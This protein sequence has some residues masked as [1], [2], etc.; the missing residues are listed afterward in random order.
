MAASLRPS[1]P[2]ARAVDTAAGGRRD[3]RSPQGIGA[4]SPTID[5]SGM[6][7]TVRTVQPT[8]MSHREQLPTSRTVA[9]L[10]IACKRF[11]GGIA[12]VAKRLE[13]SADV[14]Q[15][16]LSP[17]CATHVLSMLDAERITA[18]TSDPAGAIEFARL[19]G[20]ACIPMPEAHA[21]SLHKGMADIGQEFSDLV[22]EFS[23]ATRDNRIS[24]NECT[25]FEREL[26]ELF[27]AASHVLAN[28]R[29]HAQARKP[30]LLDEV[31]VP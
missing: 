21:G 28:M 31:R 2:S 9:A 4:T 22:R 17:T 6:A 23:D 29:E 18:A 26:T 24:D 12:E 25:R 7:R 8:R 19:A 5:V 30:V 20:L 16:K 15:K 14:L 13:M 3:A 1:P 10:L 11:R 27:V